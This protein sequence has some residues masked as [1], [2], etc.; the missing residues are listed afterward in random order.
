MLGLTD[1]PRVVEAAIG[2]TTLTR[3]CRTNGTAP[4][5]CEGPPGCG[6]GVLPLTNDPSVPRSPGLP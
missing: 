6:A 2:Q 5:A 3:A 1:S 4:T